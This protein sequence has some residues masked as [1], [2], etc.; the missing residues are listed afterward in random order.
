MDREIN[1]EEFAQTAARIREKADKEINHNK[2]GSLEKLSC[3]F[4]GK[5]QPG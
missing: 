2:G 1:L 4:T 5:N 3:S